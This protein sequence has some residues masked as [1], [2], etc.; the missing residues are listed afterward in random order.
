M[1]QHQKILLRHIARYRLT[2]KLI[3]SRVVPDA[4]KVLH[5]LATRGLITSQGEET[6]KR[7]SEKREDNRQAIGK[8][9]YF[10]LTRAGRDH[11]NCSDPTSVG[12]HLDRHLATL[13][14][15]HEDREGRSHR[16]LPSELETLIPDYMRRQVVYCLSGHHSTEGLGLFRVYAAKTQTNEIVKFLRRQ[17]KEDQD[18]EVLQRW[19][20]IGRYGY[21]ILLPS[22]S[23]VAEMKEHFRKE[24]LFE[25]V[26][27]RIALGA[28]SATFASE[29]GGP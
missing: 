8:F 7:G 27:W 4:G 28:D 1:D 13:W 20:L 11:L 29:W 6:K 21:L 9:P 24:H 22:R 3:A 2:V 14:F 5:S 18:H 17:I 12:K 16:I 15:C 10:T 19:L 25:D 23:R 26:R